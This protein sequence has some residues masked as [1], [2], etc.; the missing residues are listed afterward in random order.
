MCA[1][2]TA[3]AIRAQNPADVPIDE[4]LRDLRTDIAK[5][6]HQNK[7]A[8]LLLEKYKKENSGK[9]ALGTATTPKAKE[10]ERKKARKGCEEAS[11][12]PEDREASTHQEESGIS[13]P[14]VCWEIPGPSRMEEEEKDVVM[15]EDTEPLAT[16]NPSPT[17][18]LSQTVGKAMGGGKEQQEQFWVKMEGMVERLLDNR[19]GVTPNSHDQW[20]REKLRATNSPQQTSAKPGP[21]RRR[22]KGGTAKKR[23]REGRGNRWRRPH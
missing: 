10:E 6:R 12:L 9:K 21:P 11:L 17:N 13:L 20:K 3:L 14:H 4:Q 18:V 22:T 2:A 19:L 5:L 1:A 7:T 15:E 8:N 16:W 23:R